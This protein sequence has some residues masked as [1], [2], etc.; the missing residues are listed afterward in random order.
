M[1]AYESAGR[2]S[3]RNSGSPARRRATRSAIPIEMTGSV[4]VGK[5]ADLAVVDQNLFEI[6]TDEI[7]KARV[8]LTFVE[9]ECV[10]DASAG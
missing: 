1:T 6:P 8:E 9:G 2:I 5:Y 4:E 10:F 7:W 3:A